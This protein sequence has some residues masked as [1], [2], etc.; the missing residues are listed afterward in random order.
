MI[1]IKTKE[2]MKAR[3]IN[4]NDI[5]T[6]AKTKETKMNDVVSQD[7]KKGKKEQKGQKQKM[8][9]SKAREWNMVEISIDDNMSVQGESKIQPS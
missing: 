9:D 5:A 4:F 1:K 3:E 6:E 8:K 7:P 2:P